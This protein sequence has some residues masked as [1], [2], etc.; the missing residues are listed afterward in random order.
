MT[1]TA[2]ECDLQ[3]T[4]RSQEVES[5]LKALDILNTTDESD[6]SDSDKIDFL[7]II[8]HCLKYASDCHHV[9]TK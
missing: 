3:E 4:F 6:K 9:V 8:D 5:V 2:V 1:N 7:L